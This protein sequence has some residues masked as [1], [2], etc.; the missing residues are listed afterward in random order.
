M[1][2]LIYIPTSSVGGFLFSTS[3]P[4]FVICTLFMMAILTSVRGCLIEVLVCISLLFSKVKHLSMFLCAC[5][6]SLCFLWINVY[7][8]FLISWL[9]SLLVNGPSRVRELFLFYK[10]LPEMEVLSWFLFSFHPSQ[11]H[12]DLSCNFGFMRSS[13]TVQQVFCEDCSLKSESESHSVVSDSLQPHG[14]Y[15][16]WNYPGQTTG[17]GS[18]SFLQRIFPT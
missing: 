18:Y 7:L 12:D 9:V 3:F 11:L 14:L 10:F 1:A 13:G 17:V 5:C 2:T 4:A 15:S 6:P 8:V 16:P